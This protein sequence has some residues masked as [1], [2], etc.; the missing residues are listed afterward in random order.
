[1]FY[2]W[3]QINYHSLMSVMTNH[4]DYIKVKKHVPS[5]E[6]EYKVDSRQKIAD[7][8]P[9]VSYNKDTLMQDIKQASFSFFIYILNTFPGKIRTNSNKRVVSEIIKDLQL[10]F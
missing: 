7:Q 2:V 6:I 9:M 5:L 4:M 1:M 8:W 10:I 3:N